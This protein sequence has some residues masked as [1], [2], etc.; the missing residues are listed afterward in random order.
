MSDSNT[1][2]FVDYV[3]NR[4]KEFRI[5]TIIF[6]GW[7]EELARTIEPRP[8]KDID[9]LYIADDF[10]LVDSFMKAN[11][12][13]QEILPKHFPHKRAFM[14]NDVMI[15]LLLLIPTS[16]GYT[17]HFWNQY[18]LAWPAFDPC[19]VSVSDLMVSQITPQEIIDFYRSHFSSIE[20][21]RKM[22]IH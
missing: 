22:N 19:I 7:A 9:L 4:L 17:T 16:H 10:S 15:E 11:N 5:E 14:C 18:T 8:H 21:V 1:L 6:G 3:T 20:E 2:Q 12:D 13:I